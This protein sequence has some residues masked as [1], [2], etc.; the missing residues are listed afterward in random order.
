HHARRIALF[1]GLDLAVAAHGRGRRGGG[2]RTDGRRRGDGRTERAGTT[3]FARDEGTTP[4]VGGAGD[5]AGRI[6]LFAGLDLAIAAHGRGRR[7]GRRRDRGRGGDR[8]TERA[9]AVGLACD[10]RTTRRIGADHH[11]RRIALFA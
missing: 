11:A 9:G 6:A 7:A 3:G 4:R 5:R 1:A 10:E 8:R 2:R